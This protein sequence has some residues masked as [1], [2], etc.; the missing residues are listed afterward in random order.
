MP[1]PTTPKS[2]TARRALRRSAR[3]DNRVRRG[4]AGAGAARSRGGGPTSSGRRLPAPRSS[5]TKR[6]AGPNGLGWTRRSV[7]TPVK[8]QLPADQW[9]GTEQLLQELGLARPDQA[10]ESRRSRPSGR[11][12]RTAQ[13]P[14]ESARRGP[15][16]RHPFRAWLRA[17]ATGPPSRAWPATNSRARNGP[18]QDPVTT[19]SRSTTTRSDTSSISTRSWE[20][21][22][23]ATPL[24]GEPADGHQQA[25][26]LPR[27]QARGGLVEDE[28]L[29]VMRQ[30]P[31]DHHLLALAGRQRLDGARRRRCRSPAFSATARAA[32]RVRPALR[33]SPPVPGASESSVRLSATVEPG[34]MP[35]SISWWTVWMPARRASRGVAGANGSPPTSTVPPDAPIAPERILISVDFPAPLV[36]MRPTTSPAA[37]SNETRLRTSL[38]P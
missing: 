28:H 9:S 12:G 5:A 37:T 36:P 8:G 6:D 35:A 4:C 26:G 25:F 29:D 7:G 32:C 24:R 16:R 13:R 31:G 15:P 14:A 17:P 18:R 23:T 19:P 21:N 22:R 20:T 3:L 38:A 34:T 2:S 33:N 1:G 27:R 30:R 11:R 10:G